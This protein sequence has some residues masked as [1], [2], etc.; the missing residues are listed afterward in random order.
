MTHKSYINMIYTVCFWNN[1]HRSGALN[2]NFGKPNNFKILGTTK[3]KRPKHDRQI[4]LRSHMAEGGALRYVPFEVI[5]TRWFPHSWL[6]TW[7]VTRVIRRV[8]YME[9]VPAN[10]SI[11]FSNNSD[12]VVLFVSVFY[13]IKVL[14]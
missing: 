1:R 7:F 10:F 14:C 2:R 11:V 12:S 4:R 9:Q 13:V 6:I 5:L 3:T 8:T